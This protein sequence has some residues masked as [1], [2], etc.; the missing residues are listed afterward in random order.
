MLDTFLA[1]LVPRLAEDALVYVELAHAVETLRSV[2]SQFA[3]EKTSKA[4]AVHF[5]LLRLISAG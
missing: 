4:G 5:G 3:V 2:R 1:Q